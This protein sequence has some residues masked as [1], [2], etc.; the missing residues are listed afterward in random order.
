MSLSSCAAAQGVPLF[1]SKVACSTRKT[2]VYAVSGGSSLVPTRKKV[3]LISETSC[4]M[5]Q[6]GAFM[7]EGEY[8]TSVE[9]PARIGI[10]M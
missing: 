9:L 3:Q 4:V 2:R 6:D 5:I 7:N 10:D 1:P 8:G